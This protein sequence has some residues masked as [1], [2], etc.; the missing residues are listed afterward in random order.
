[1]P[2]LAITI[3]QRRALRRWRNSQTPLPSHKACIDWFYTQFN[4]KISQSTVSESLSAR[5]AHLDD[6]AASAANS[7][8]R[9]R[10]GQ[11]D[12]LEQILAQWQHRIEARGGFT[13]GD[14]IRQKAQLLWHQL[15]QYQGKPR[16]EFNNTGLRVT[17]RDIGSDYNNALEKT[18]LYQ[19]L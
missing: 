6:V 7:Q 8:S 13:T 14:I 4:H 18:L 16:P 3:E 11:W 2:R 12:D 1:M 5:F 15:P 10:T 17:R 9:H 19:N